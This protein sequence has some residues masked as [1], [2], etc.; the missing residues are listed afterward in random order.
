MVHYYNI[1]KGLKI[2]LLY[3]PHLILQ[4]KNFKSQIISDTLIIKIQRAKNWKHKSIEFRYF[5]EKIF[6]FQFHIFLYIEIKL[7]EVTRS[8]TQE[9]CQN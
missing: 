9:F 7:T 3:N 5:P 4:T 8:H 1:S 2:N 6:I